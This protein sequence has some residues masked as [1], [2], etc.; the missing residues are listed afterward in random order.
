MNVWTNGE[1]PSRLCRTVNREHP[2]DD[3]LFEVQIYIEGNSDYVTVS[4]DFLH[5]FFHEIEA[6]DRIYIGEFRFFA[7]EYNALADYWLCLKEVGW[8]SFFL[9]WRWF[10]IRKAAIFE[11]RLIRTFILW[12]LGTRVHY[13]ETPTWDNVRLWRKRA[14]H[15]S[16]L[17][18]LLAALL[19]LI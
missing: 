19:L 5:D 3:V 13:G 16:H 17:V 9:K 14:Y 7:L 11:Q 4:Y 12:G 8:W 10:V 15:P 2:N 6:G 1:Y 18:I